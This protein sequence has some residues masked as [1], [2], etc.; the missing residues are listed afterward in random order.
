MNNSAFG[1]TMENLHERIN[2]ELINNAKDY[3]KCVSKPN[4]ISQKILVKI[5]L[6][7]IK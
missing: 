7:F 1:K 2:V 5:L 4:F 3:G 6:L